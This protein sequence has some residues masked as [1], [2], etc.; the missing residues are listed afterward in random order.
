VTHTTG[1]VTEQELELVRQGYQLWNRGDFEGVAKLCF[2]EDLV[3]QNSP[4][5]PGPRTYRGQEEV[6][7]FLRDEVASVIELGDIEIES[8]DVYGDEVVIRML[9]RTRG[10]GSELDIGKI[11]IF[12]VARIRDG[13]V[14]RVRVYLD[15][16]EAVAAAQSSYS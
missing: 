11:P 1:R 8:L 4:E 3:W 14:A 10:A 5:W 13:R 16:A 6:I 15:H 7:A 2:A 12:H 9:A